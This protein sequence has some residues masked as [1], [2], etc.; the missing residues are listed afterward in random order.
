MTD[1]E[2]AQKILRLSEAAIFTIDEVASIVGVKPEV[3]RNWMSRG[4]VDLRYTVQQG[5]GNRILF[6][7]GDIINLVIVAELSHLTIDPKTSKKFSSV[8]M[9]HTIRKIKDISGLYGDDSRYENFKRYAILYSN[10]DYGG[11]LH[12]ILWNE[13]LPKIDTGTA[14][15]VARIVVDC[16]ELAHKVIKAMK[17]FANKG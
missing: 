5:Y 14:R 16:L 13:P 8:I 11:E 7:F 3:I 6:S 4:R 15:D 10:W 2:A 9:D 12:L 17:A 1:Q